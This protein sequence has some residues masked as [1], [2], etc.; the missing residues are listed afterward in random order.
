MQHGTTMR[1]VGSVFHFDAR[2]ARSKSALIQDFLLTIFRMKPQFVMK[3]VLGSVWRRAS[4]LAIITSTT[5]FPTHLFSQAIAYNLPLIVT[6]GE[7]N[8][9][10][11]VSAG[12]QGAFV[13]W[14]DERDNH[15]A[16]Y[17]Q[18]LNALSQPAWK[19]NGILV[20]TATKDQIA[21]T[22]ISDG[23]GGILIF[24][25]DLRN[26][27]GD[28]FG[29]R[30]DASG[31]L[32][33]GVG[34]ASIVRLSGK[35]AEPQAVSDG[36]D[37]ALVLWREYKTGNEDVF[38]QR[39]DGAGKILLATTGRAVAQGSG[40]QIL[41]EAAATTDG[42]VVVAW[43]DNSSGLDRVAALRFD[44]QANPKWNASVFVTNVRS[45]PLTPAIYFSNDNTFVIWGDDRNRTF[46]LYAQKI[47]AAGILQWGLPGVAVC[48][49]TNDQYAQ[50]IFSDGS[51]GMLVVWEDKR[52]GKPDVYAQ[53]LTAAGQA[54]WQTDGVAIAA[55]SQEQFE[56]RAVADGSGGLICVWT[57]ERGSGTNIAAQRLDKTG[58]AL[59]A[60]NG[61]FITNDSGAKQQ[62]AV[63][64]L[65]D[66]FL[67]EGGSLVAWD[68]SRRDD[69]DIFVQAL[70]GDGALANVPPSIT[71]SPVT[72]APAGQAYSYKVQ[73]HDFDSVDPLSLS[74][75]A[76]PNA[77]WLQVDNAQ[78]K[79]LGTPPA[80]AAGEV[81][82]TLT[83]KDKLGAQAT[84]SFTL[85]VINNN[86]PPQIT[87]KPDTLATEDLLYFYQI[88]A[89]DP[90]AG[91]ILTR[92]LETE[93]TWLK[94]AND[95]RISGTPANE[96]VGRYAVTVR[97]SDKQGLTV[98]QQFSLR[99]KNVNDLPVIASQPDTV[100][101]E[102]QLYSYKIFAADPDAGDALTFF[103][104]LPPAWLK[105]DD[106]G[107]ISGTPKNEQVGSHLVTLRAVDKQGATAIQRFS[108]RVKNVN[109]APA[110]VSQPDTI[111]FAD[112]LYSYRVNVADADRGDVV[113]ISKSSGPSWLIWNAA[114]RT[115][116]GRP[117]APLIGAT[118]SVTLLAKDLA[119]AAVEQTFRL[120]II[121]GNILD[122][123]APMAPQALQI[124]PAQW[125]AS[126]KFTLT[127]Q[128]PF[129]PSRITSAYYKIGAPPLHDRDGELVSGTGGASLTQIEALV[130]QEGQSQIYLWLIDGRGNVD[131]RS[132]ANT[133]YRYD[134]TPP[135][136]PQNLA[137]NR[138]WT[139]G[140]SV[141][142][143][144]TPSTDAMS[145]LRRYHFFLDG[146]FFGFFAGNTSEFMLILQLAEQKHEWTFMAEDSAGNLSKWVAASFQVD[147]QAPRLSHTAIDTASA[148]TP[149]VVSMQASDASAGVRET[150]LYY[151]AAGKKLYRSKNLTAA[152]NL[153]TTQVDA[154]EVAAQGL[155]YYLEAADSAGNRTPWPV[156]A[157]AQFQSVMV[158]SANIN[159]PIAFAAK[160]YQIFSAPYRLREE[161]PAKLFEDDWGSY[162]PASWR[163]FRY[164][165]GEGN[166]EFGK[167][168]LENFA[169]GRAY[170]LI[171]SQ[172]QNFDVGAGH[173]LRSNE[174][175]ALTLQPGWNLIATPFD[176][177]TAWSAVQRPES[178]ENN[179]WGF[180]GT[181]Y[182]GQQET[183]QPW[184]GY[185]VRN[186]E[187][188]PQVISIA[189]VAAATINKS[190]APEIIWQMQLRVSD[191]EFSDDAN[192]IGATTRAHE[193]WDPL[194]LSE[195]PTIGDYVSLH[196]A[197]YDWPR[198]AGVFTSDFR[199]LNYEIQKW[200]FTVVASRPGLP[201]ELSWDFFGE[202]PTDWIF[203]LQDIDGNLKRQYQP[204]KTR[205][206][207]GNRYVFRATPQPRN[208][209]W[210]AG[211]PAQ[212]AEMGAL[213]DIVPAAFELAPSYPNPLQLNGRAEVGVIRFGLPAAST[214]RVTIFDVVGREVRALLAGK[215]LAAG[216]HEMQ[217]DGRDNIGRAVP[218]GIYLYRL[219]TAHFS[220]SRKLILL[221]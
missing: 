181:K 11:L 155:E 34:G 84:Q 1:Q 127:W 149:L 178:V 43:S 207:D 55:T 171:T 100:T 92:S 173:S 203:V 146:K 54:R 189:P 50:Q 180:D 208:L 14:Q 17:A 194:D 214:V 138:Q 185:F 22:A 21:P 191:G 102:D 68:D 63:L 78:L 12:K 70:K 72:E 29:Q 39:V 186:L 166:V 197:R 87:S 95:G 37:G 7:Q 79:L 113:Q 216:Y 108:V 38:L 42:G 220:A 144:W 47:D 160:R 118:F 164:Q 48:K 154:A 137:P 27:D 179:L 89:T 135:P 65:P 94:L 131:F 215:N 73:A 187:A 133:F 28:I 120:R 174:P 41:G 109:D 161:S 58:K 195:P 204:E 10:R 103:I 66:A 25:Q 33:W 104:D 210:W 119:N 177:P 62:P 67:G 13:V 30:L 60:T 172:P 156:N 169:P 59:W 16:I 219:E 128:N 99:V 201:V 106:T 77:T 2:G 184:Q 198:Y 112:S 124:Q 150:R 69:S 56:P 107:V 132:A 57:D 88:I 46:D 81:A 110:F 218:A 71:S 82:I 130:K 163:L 35:Q 168:H 15:W 64:A 134:A 90:D 20:A 175:F 205:D 211:K 200:P 209:V 75:V 9:P 86:R 199:P 152:E 148:S 147:R 80:N 142:L 140:D 162:D 182:L 170:W 18:H 52:S 122:V 153:F 183:L 165:P 26:D 49:A 96:N 4:I 202:L 23:N 8:V 3:S 36:V 196:F 143:Q 217:W 93:A 32:L 139:R 105:L 190:P 45:T 19:P 74:F 167:P 193:T 31:N 101:L 136:P 24:W 192:F 51:D 97:V 53:A 6:S 121:P 61:I 157:P 141:R 114:T 5:L 123:T 125:S 111:A 98:T 158:T 151:R 206:G 117:G 159:A 76:A 145:G 44:A 212:L 129:D 40:N 85:T 126:Q 83:I 176:F 188:Q 116:Q 91:D 213:E 115:L 221:R